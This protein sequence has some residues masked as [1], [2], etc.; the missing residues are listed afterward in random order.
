[1][2]CYRPLKAFR[3]AGGGITF[4]E[5]ARYDSVG[6]IEVPC[7]QCIG[8]RVRKSS[9]W[10]LRFVHEASMHDANCFV[11]LTYEGDS[12][13]PDG[14]LCYRD[15]QLFMKRV[16]KRLGPVRFGMCGEYGPV[17][18]RPHYH[19]CL[20]GVDFRDRVY[21]C[22]SA[23][24]SKVYTSA[25]LTSLWSH[26]FATVQDYCRETGGYC[27]RYIH[28]KLLGQEARERLGPIGLLDEYVDDDGVIHG[29]VPEF[30]RYSLKPG[31]GEAW[32]KKYGRDVF[33]H[34]YAVL[35]GSKRQPP[36][37]YDK[38]HKRS[39]ADRDELEYQRELRARA[40]A[41]DQTAERRVVR[42]TVHN[43]KLAKHVR[44][45]L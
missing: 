41:A 20:F 10:E 40:S 34:D 45:D 6:D 9:D 17:N 3:L 24:G 27:A 31:I 28:K 12:L 7:G 29:R 38:L 43:A 14:S 35:D 25:L 8:C 33:R 36:K 21:H 22:K 44:G 23:A 19:A 13:P 4:T 39:G 42:E 26:G 18:L 32:F 16:R 2:S 11:T 15:F 37:Y 1:M 30:G 5:L